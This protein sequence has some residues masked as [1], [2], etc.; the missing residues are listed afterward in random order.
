MRYSPLSGK[1]RFTH[2]K[3]VENYFVGIVDVTPDSV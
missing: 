3:T 2:G 1:Q